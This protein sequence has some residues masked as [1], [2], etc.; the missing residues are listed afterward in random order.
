[1][2]SYTINGP[3]LEITAEGSY[4][5]EDVA[6]VLIAAK[7]DARLISPTLL[8]SDFRESHVTPSFADVNARLSLTQEH[9]APTLAALVISGVA[10]ERLAHIYQT[11]AAQTSG[12][13]I[14]VFTDPQAA[15]DWLLR[16]AATANVKKR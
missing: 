7:A 9:V 8:L 1:M 5:T 16:N 13:Q 15:R 6:S 14:E 11:R 2:V 4:T 3:I 12:L 10:R